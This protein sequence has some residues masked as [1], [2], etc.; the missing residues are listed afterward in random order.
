MFSSQALVEVVTGWL[1]FTEELAGGF[2]VLHLLI[3]LVK[4]GLLVG[5]PAA[6][7]TRGLCQ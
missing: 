1:V 5:R 3:D 7:Q 2:Q 6:V 4:L